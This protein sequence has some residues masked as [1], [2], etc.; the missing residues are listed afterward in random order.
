MSCCAGGTSV[1]ALG[2]TDIPSRDAVLHSSQSLDDGTVRTVLAVPDVHCG[3]CIRKV[4]GAL[5]ALPE[6][7]EARVN[8]STKRVT[9]HWRKTDVDAEPVFAALR[10]TGYEPNLISPDAIVVDDTRKTLF[11]A[12]AVAGFAAGNIMLLSVSVWS[13]A[14]AATRDLFH[15][16][17][18]LIA[19]PT[20]GYSGR[21]FFRP[22]LKALAARSL[23]MDVPISLAILLATGM[24]IYETW[25]HGEHAYFDAS[26]T[27][28]FFLLIGRTLDHMMRERARDAVAGLARITP[29]GAT[30][31]AAD[32][33]RHWHP[34]NEIEAGMRLHIAAGDRIPVDALVMEGK[35]DI[36]AAIATGESVPVTA[37]EGT[38]LSAGM[39]NLT[40]PLVVEATKAAKDS[41]LSEMLRMLDAAEGGAPAY[42][43]LADRAAAIYAPVVHLAALLTF[44]GWM[45]V[46][47]DWR[48]SLFSAI[49]VLI[50]TCPCALGL[51]VPIVQVV[52]ASRLFRKGI[53]V[54]DGTALEKLAQVDR[55]VFDKTGTL[56]VGTPRLQ[57]VGTHSPRVLAIA[58]ALGANSRHPYSQALVRA[59]DEGNL[60]PVNGMTDIREIPGEGIEGRLD[61]EAYFLGRSA[62]GGN[63]VEL[64]RDGAAVDLFRFEDRLR[65]NAAETIAALEA[66]DIAGEILS[67][68]NE[69]TVSATAR[70]LGMTD[71]RGGLRPADK[72]ARVQALQAAG[73]KVLMVG[74]GLN[75]APSLAAADVSM[76][77]SK[78][79]D[80]GR[81]AAGLVFL[82]EGLDA[83]SSAV[84]VARRAE[85]LIRQNFA[86][87]V[88]YNLIA[89]PLAV[90]GY[91]S[92]LVAAL[93]M[94]G[95]SIIVILN[96]LRLNEAA[97]APFSALGSWIQRRPAQGTT[98]EA[99]IATP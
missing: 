99:G 71:W 19:I 76:V 52:A 25:H 48:Q 16:I 68:D 77:P 27:L 14:E 81:Q 39:L 12:L 31:I 18:A 49:A 11:R 9:F 79:A 32:G 7:R 91:A 51:A 85:V 94:S 65:A 4:E 10:R 57:E 33:S 87:A 59:A 70:A 2:T 13:G 90:L 36:D 41:F 42:R 30:V 47:G 98:G 96:A 46:T 6:I 67:G 89:I 83:V 35:S 60:R 5:N 97:A 66:R 20:V 8:L 40:G 43:K 44:L 54:R 55:V 88:I 38:P 15:W 82:H 50:I 21:V 56:T 92:P 80:I 64:R 22:A 95:S 37:T 74:D 86:L 75:D 26:V 93:A 69:Q 1:S 23:N 61:G 63:G 28:L 72:I 17:S 3:A 29:D 24:S 84:A 34:L 58:A 62:T 45:W 53:M 73:H 78:A